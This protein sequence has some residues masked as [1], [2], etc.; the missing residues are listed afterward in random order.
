MTTDIELNKRHGNRE[1]EKYGGTSWV[2][3]K[4]SKGITVNR[5]ECFTKTESSYIEG[6]MGIPQRHRH[7]TFENFRE[8]NQVEGLAASVIVVLKRF[9][10][11]YP[12][13]NSKGVVISAGPLVDDRHQ[14]GRL[15]SSPRHVP[16]SQGPSG[17]LDRHL[18]GATRSWYMRREPGTSL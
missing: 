6:Q 16:V 9:V 18:L 15:S 2:Q 12:T 13:C 4:T 10:S 17:L 11:D 1:C 3:S 5:C 8:S 7:S 14:A